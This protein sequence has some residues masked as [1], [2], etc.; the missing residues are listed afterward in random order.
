MY[1]TEIEV[2]EK[3]L[4]KLTNTLKKAYK[5]I[6]DEMLNA[7]DFGLYNRQMILAQVDRHLENLG[8]DVQKFI[9][10]ELPKY[11]KRGA[12]DAIKQMRHIDA[13]IDVAYGFNAVHIEAVQA[14]ISDTAKAFGE[15]LTG[16][17]R[18][19]NNVLGKM[20]REMITQKLAEGVIGGKATDEVRKQIKGILQEQGLSA[21]VDKGGRTWTLDRYTEM[22][23]RTKAVEARNRG[24]INRVVENRYDLVQIS[25]HFTDCELCAPWEGKIISLT[26]ETKGYP[27]LAQAEKEGLFHPNC[28]HAINTFNPEL[29]ELTHAYDPDTKTYK[30]PQKVA[31]ETLEGSR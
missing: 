26:G 14:L 19:A 13:P 10:K 11:Y 17:S 16:I 20:A 7:T 31:K 1:P 22:L 9:E 5:E 23:I 21:L 24:L 30:V 27:T 8:V 6:V 3:A 18:S 29:A 25:S 4:A 28:K 12:D 15:T 2:D